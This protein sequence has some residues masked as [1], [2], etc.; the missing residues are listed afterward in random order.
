M[1]TKFS[2]MKTYL[3]S[4]VHIFRDENRGSRWRPLGLAGCVCLL[5]GKPDRRWNHVQVMIVIII[6]MMMSEF[7]SNITESRLVVHSSQVH[8]S[9]IATE[10]D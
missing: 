8:S 5:H 1:L 6:T 3:I 4:A 7:V 2:K 10:E 9:K